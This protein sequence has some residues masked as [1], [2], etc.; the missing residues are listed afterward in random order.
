M[1]S[2]L[3]Q[4]YACQFIANIKTVLNAASS[5]WLLSSFPPLTFLR[6]TSPF[7]VY[8]SLCIN[9]V[10]AASSDVFLRTQK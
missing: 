5:F 9:V 8:V 3:W 10:Q 2:N 1:D 7:T 4:S 6:K